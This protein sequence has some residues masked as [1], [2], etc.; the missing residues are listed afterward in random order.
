MIVTKK[1]KNYHAILGWFNMIGCEKCYRGV[2]MRSYGSEWVDTIIRL[3]NDSIHFCPE[4][5]QD[6]KTLLKEGI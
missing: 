2:L 6:L 4:H 3:S 1:D 5:T